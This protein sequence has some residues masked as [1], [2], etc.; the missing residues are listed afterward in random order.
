VTAPT[1][2]SLPV[3]SSFV[4][5][6]SSQDLA[7]AT[8]VTDRSDVSW[9]QRTRL[10]RDRLNLSYT[11]KFERNHTFDTEP[12]NNPLFP[13]FDITIKIARLIGAGAWDSRDDAG[14]TTRGSLLS[15]TFEYAPASL[16]SDI[17]YVQHL[18]QAYH[19]RS[20]HGVVLGSAARVG[21]VSPL[22]GQELIPSLRFFSGGARTVRGVPEDGLGPRDFFGD[23]AGGEALLVLNQ[24][25]RFPIYR[26]F[27]GVGFV[28][29][30][31]VFQHPSDFGLNNLVGAFGAGVRVVTP[32]ALLRVDY[33]RKAW[34]GP[35]TDSGHWF[36]G[37]GQ[38]F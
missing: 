29:A 16:G 32:V 28:D 18:A 15:Y 26:W 34:P 8:L 2:F 5:E 19:F 3:S 37:V 12:S 20:W 21:F 25:A 35:Q 30:G 27:R 23:P 31:N 17:R 1:L 38:S 13:T 4:L 10:A 22:A 11:Y 33:G 14:D 6:R 7:A 9:E 24:E 36:F